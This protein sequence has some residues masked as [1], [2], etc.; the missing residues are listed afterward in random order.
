MCYNFPHVRVTWDTKITIITVIL[1]RT[2]RWILD[3]RLS[4]NQFVLPYQKG[5]IILCV[6]IAT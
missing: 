4:F 2:I 6:E 5:D 3:A 1:S